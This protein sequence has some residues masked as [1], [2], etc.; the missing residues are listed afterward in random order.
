VEARAFTL[1]P[2]L[3]K[4]LEQGQLMQMRKVEVKAVDWTASVA[5]LSVLLLRVLLDEEVGDCVSI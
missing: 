2:V 1:T 4:S 3:C 5:W